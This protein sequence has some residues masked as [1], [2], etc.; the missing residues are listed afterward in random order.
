MHTFF[1]FESN[2]EITRFPIE[3]SISVKKIRFLTGSYVACLSA[4]SESPRDQGF[5]YVQTKTTS[6]CAPK[7]RPIGSGVTGIKIIMRK[8]R[9]TCRVP[10]NGRLPLRARV[11]IGSSCLPA[12][13]VL[14]VALPTPFCPGCERVSRTKRQIRYRLGGGDSH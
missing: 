6:R 1:L 3:T 7:G 4:E 2:I 14:S 5:L 11:R 8:I 12:N 13:L 10:K 9:K